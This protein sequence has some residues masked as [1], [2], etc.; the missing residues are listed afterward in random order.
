MTSCQVGS[1]RP[2]RGSR[3]QLLT[4][5]RPLG[6]VEVARKQL[7]RDL[8]GEV[9]DADQRLKALTIQLAATVTEHGSTLT[10][11]DGVGPV[12]AARLL[13]RTRRASRFPSTSGLRSGAGSDPLRR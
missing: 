5:V 1:H 3:S 4:A 13:G 2:Q 10:M 7:A 9:R 8:V 11:L 6:P 12:V